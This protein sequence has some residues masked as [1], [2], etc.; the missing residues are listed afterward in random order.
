MMQLVSLF[1]VVLCVEA[2][3]LYGYLS[4]KDDYCGS[5][6]SLDDEI[7]WVLRTST[8]SCI[9][10]GEN[11]SDPNYFSST[12][13]INADGFRVD[14]TASPTPTNGML[15]IGDSWTFGYGIDWEDSFAAQLTR[16]YGRPT[17]LLASPA[18]SGAQ[19]LLLARRHIESLRANTIIYLELGNWDRSVCSGKTRPA[20]IL[21]PCYWVDGDDVVHLVT[22]RPGYVHRMSSIGLRPGGM[23]GAGEKTLAYFLIA[24]PVA[25][26]KQ[27]M[28][29]LRL[30]SG[31]GN[32]FAAWGRE[33]D[34]AKIRAAHLEQLLLFAKD[35]GARLLL[36][37]PGE[38]YKPHAL[39]S[40]DKK[41][42]IYIGRS[43]WVASVKKPMSQLPKALARVPGDGHFG[44]GTHRLI[45]ALIDA[46]LQSQN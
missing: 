36:I 25:K 3:Y 22:P 28:V 40:S 35:A 5:F 9:K 31:F 45:A 23:V 41:S 13:L 44:P 10:S 34:F 11:A 18:Y 14:D 12:I 19:A 37:D 33:E 32:D 29:R 16:S 38:V 4:F 26:I 42:L 15:A 20:A 46:K 2:Y 1:L 17:A 27:L 43:E 6:A 21:K 39:D 30:L 24:R 8:S 7:G